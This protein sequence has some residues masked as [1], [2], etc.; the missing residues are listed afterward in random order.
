MKK[1]VSVILLGCILLLAACGVVTAGEL[2]KGIAQEQ[3]IVYRGGLDFSEV[4]AVGENFIYACLEDG[5][6]IYQVDPSGN[7]IEQ[8][9]LPVPDEM[10]I[11]KVIIDEDNL[12]H[13]LLTTREEYVTKETPAHVEIWQANETGEVLQKATLA[14]VKKDEL[15]LMHITNLNENGVFELVKT[16]EEKNAQE[17]FAT[18]ETPGEAEKVVLG[19]H[20]MPDGRLLVIDTFMENGEKVTQFSFFAEKK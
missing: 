3:V 8:F 14:D 19:Q 17:I 4:N 9:P 5:K 10:Q 1:G 11:A 16:E 15:S 13:I 6:G 2:G 20:I 18:L 7:K 12:V